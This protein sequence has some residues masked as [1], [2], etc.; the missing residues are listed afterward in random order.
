MPASE[1]QIRA[2]Q[3]NAKR[4]KGPTSISGRER[5]RRNGLKH[6][7][8]GQGVVIPEEDVD[9]VEARNDALQAELAPQS[10]MGAILVRQLATLSVRMERGAKQESAAIAVRV[11]H[12]EEAFDEGRIEQVDRFFECLDVDPRWALRQLRRMPEGVDRLIEAWAALRDVLTGGRSIWTASHSQKAANLSGLLA[13]EA[14]GRGWR[15]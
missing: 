11:R 8:T 14:P 1:A 9:E 5:S 15:R 6:G 13:E 2:N 4:S 12:A 7:L 3:A 10:A